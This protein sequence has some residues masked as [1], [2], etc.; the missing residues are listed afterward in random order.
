MLRR[1]TLRDVAAAAIV[2]TNSLLCFLLLLLAA[3][4]IMRASSRSALIF[5]ARR[6]LPAVSFPLTKFEKPNKLENPGAKSE[7][8]K[9]TLI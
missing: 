3:H 6:S 2:P 4:Y 8:P 9:W 7:G 5:T 1:R